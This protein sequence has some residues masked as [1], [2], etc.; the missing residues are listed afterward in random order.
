MIH[1]EATITFDAEA[2][3]NTN[4]VSNTIDADAP[5]SAVN[6]LPATQSSPT[7]NLSW[8]GQDAPNGSGLLNYDIFFSA[9]N[10][11]YQLLLAGGTATSMQFTAEPGTT[12]RFYSLARDNTGNVEAAPESP[13]AVT[14]AEAVTPTPTPTPIP[15]PTP[16][17]M[18]SP[19][20]LLISEFRLQGA[21]PADEFIEIY[22]NTDAPVDILNYQLTLNETLPRSTSIAL[23]TPGPSVIPARGHHLVAHQTGYSLNAYVSRDLGS[24]L[25]F[26][27]A[28]DAG[29]TL[30][31]SANV[32]LDKVGFST[33]P[34]DSCEG[35]CLTPTTAAGQ[36]SFARR[37]ESGYPKDTD[38][39][40]TDFMLVATDPAGLGAG[41]RLGAPGPENIASPR[42]KRPIRRSRRA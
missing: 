28:P 34:A 24:S 26:D 15:T 17:P 41:S 3:I 11:P 1:N 35:A 27:F 5:A 2:A 8:A 10:G 23:G 25:G 6:S 19:G 36:Y 30:H 18:P 4:R 33:S 9:N 7:F 38:D 42:L 40:A 29:I 32:L 16:A 37:M 31:T 13:D 14:A 21:T 20:Q 22:N 39:N 12:Y